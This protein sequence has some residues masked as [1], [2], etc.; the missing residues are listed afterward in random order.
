MCGHVWACSL[1]CGIVDGVLPLL[2]P[3]SLI[4]EPLEVNEEDWRESPY[5]HLLNST[6]S[7]VLTIRAVPMGGAWV[8]MC[9]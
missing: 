3:Q 1:L 4:G 7:G 9:G 8:V 2:S 6:A 5:V